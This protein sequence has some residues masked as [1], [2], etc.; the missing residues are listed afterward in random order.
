MARGAARGAS[1]VASPSE[2]DRRR[3]ERRLRGDLDNILLAALRREPERRYGSVTAFADDLRRHLEGRPVKARARTRSATAS[4]KFVRRNRVARRGARRSRAG[5]ARR[6]SRRRGVAGAPR[7][8]A[9]RRRRRRPRAGRKR[10]KEFLIGLFEVADPEQASGR[11]DHGER[12]ARP[13]GQAPRDGAL[14]RARHP[15]GSARGRRAHRQGARTA[16]RRPEDLAKR[17]LEIRERIL[18]T[19]DAAIGRSLATLGAVKMSKGKLD[20]A[21]KGARRAPLTMLEATERPDSLATARARS[22]YG[23]VLFW[24][25]EAARAAEERARRLRDLP[26]GARRRQRPDRD[27]PAQPRACCSTSST[28]STRPRR[29]I[30]TPRPSS[31]KRLGPE[32]VEPRLE[33]REPR[34]APRA[35]GAAGRRGRGSLQALAGDPP[36]GARAEAPDGRPDAAADRA[37]LPESGAARR[38]GDDLPRGARDLSSD[39]SE[40]LRGRQVQERPRARR[41]APRELRRGGEDAGRGRGALPRGPRRE[42]LRSRGRS[43]ATAPRRSASRAGSRRPRRSSARSRRSSRS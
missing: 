34:R 8:G 7:R 43:A 29:R 36:Q 18:P 21:E 37:L 32:H 20:E 28:G 12:A 10:V 11:L 14:V 16:R 19:G 3:L 4:A 35:S 23:Q 1:A 5:L 38:V 13:G 33:L 22:D 31:T 42:A 30:G 41:V 6:R 39:R 15:G 26:P 24:K 2:A 27:A 17:S 25:G 40:A 9:T